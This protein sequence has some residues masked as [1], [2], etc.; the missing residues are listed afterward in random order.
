[1][2][3]ALFSSGSN[4]SNSRSARCCVDLN[5]GPTNYCTHN[6]VNVHFSSNHHEIQ[7]IPVIAWLYVQVSTRS[8]SSRQN[9]SG[10]LFNDCNTV[11][12]SVLFHLEPLR[13]QDLI[14][15]SST[16]RLCFLSAIEHSSDFSQREINSLLKRIYKKSL[17]LGLGSDRQTDRQT[18][19]QADMV[20]QTIVSSLLTHHND[21]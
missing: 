9:G 12:M 13:P 21:R 1:M 7:H 10:C 19:K 11:R 4:I 15:C 20:S 6:R 17:G 2:P 14:R 16:G 5:P 8:T 3:N 18:G